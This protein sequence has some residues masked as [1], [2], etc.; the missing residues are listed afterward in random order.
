MLGVA[1]NVTHEGGGPSGEGVAHQSPAMQE[2]KGGRTHR[3]NIGGNAS[4]H[5]KDKKCPDRTCAEC[6]IKTPQQKTP[7]MSIRSMY[8]EN[9]KLHI[10]LS[11]VCTQMRQFKYIV[12][13]WG[14]YPLQ[15]SLKMHCTHTETA[16]L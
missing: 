9:C 5:K 10:S 6:Q 2:K 14:N 16:R 15:K 1:Q 4:L 3:V 13:R 11:K 8:T 12:G 7:K